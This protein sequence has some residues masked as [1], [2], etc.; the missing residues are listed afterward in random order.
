M[1]EP[2]WFD[3][4]LEEPLKP[5][6]P[7]TCLGMTFENDEA[8]RA[9]FTEELRKKLQDPEFRKIAGFPLGKDEDIL[10]LSDPPYYTACPNPWIAEF[11]RVHGNSAELEVVSEPY[12]G[13]LI[14]TGRHPVYSFHPYHTKVPPEIIKELITYY[15]SP[16]DL[17]LDIFAGTGMTAVAAREC[18]RNVIVNDLSPI[19]AFISSVNSSLFDKQLFKR[20]IENLIEEAERAFGWVY[21]TEDAGG[22][23]IVNYYVWTDVF[24]CPECVHEFPF[25]PHGVIHHGNKVETKKQFACPS[26]SAD[27]N[28]RKVE[29]VLTT[30]GKRKSLAWVN[31]GS[32]RNR[33]NREPNNF[34][35]DVLAKVVSALRD[36]PVW[37]PSDPIDPAGYSAKLAQLG[38][39]AIT[40]VSKFL[41]ER[42]RLVFA[43]L[44]QRMLDIQNASIR[45]AIRSCLTSIFTVV[46]ERQGYFGGGGGMSGNLYMP[47][48]RM[49]KNI[50][51]SLRRKIKKFIDAENSKCRNREGYLVTNQSAT[52]LSQISDASI[53]YIYTDPP[54]GANIIYS[55]MNLI[56]EGWL[57]IKTNNTTEAVIDETKLKE[58]A[59][60]GRLML[61]AL[62]ECYRV[63]KP[64]KWITV[65]F[66]NTQAS[67][68]NLIQNA[69]SEAGFIVGQVC[70][71]DKGSTTILADIRPGAV[72]QDLIISAYKPSAQF[73]NKF[74]STAGEESGAWEFVRNYL[75]HLPVYKNV[76]S[77]VAYLIE[78]DPRILFDRMVAYYVRNGYPV[79]ISNQEFQIGL[80]QRFAERDGMFFLPVQAAQYDKK[81]LTVKRLIHDSAFIL[82]ESSAIE[83]LRTILRNK[84]QTFQALHP[85]FL[86]EIGGWR[87]N[88][89]ALE[90]STL[91]EQNFLCFEGHGEVP[92]SIHSYLSSNWPE[93]RNLAKDDP[94]LIAK[95][96]DRWYLPNPNKAG[97]LEKLR[98]RALLRE[99]E[100]YT[101]SKKQLTIFRLE[102]VRAGFKKAWQERDYALIVAVAD[103]IPHN[104][105]E[106]D[107]KLLMWY[108]QAVTRMG[109]E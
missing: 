69:I 100:E 34:D 39:K 49:E 85:Q 60:Y 6:G 19:A 92:N 56:L 14:S 87:K 64:G 73:I 5:S 105:L 2:S 1:K 98:E 29:R 80:R 63:L 20:E 55:E 4:L 45:N 13:D 67:V 54:F 24:N 70:K 37:I 25:F 30:D 22:R 78:R 77:D 81:R 15:T 8:R 52:E 3:S 103:K 53:D 32:G 59:D 84:P 27:L 26:C 71:L 18:G 104:V 89:K 11:L 86:S 21:E 51:D 88:E 17:V 35:R 74:N 40:D 90:L 23:A 10:N 62:K 46:S 12:S 102:A 57:R 43:D 79:P 44:W 76:G 66:H 38:D 41:S 82:D 48:I 75:S 7:V 31:A 91:L 50:Y 42:N 68:W 108:D 61:R 33:I 106:E 96:I 83:W 16:G 28:V 47:I 101:K 97:D 95:A 72:V 9:H 94:G 93:V 109:G 107:P 58:F 36:I 65:E 99:F